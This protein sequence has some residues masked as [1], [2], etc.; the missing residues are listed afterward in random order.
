MENKRGQIWVETVIYTL[1]ALILIGL[2]LSF[3][4]P[5]ITEV[6]D[7]SVIQQ[8]ISTLNEINN[9]VTSIAAEGPGNKREVDVSLGE[10]MLMIDGV[11]NQL[12]FSLQST[13]Q[14]S[15][16]EK[17]VSYGNIVIFDHVENNLNLI[18]LTLNYSQYNITYGGQNTQGF[19]TAAS[20]PYK[21]F[22]T[23]KGGNVTNIDFSLG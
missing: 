8:S 5:K 23:N 9:V 7:K 6:Q 1:I 13:Y 2:V 19:I 16:P 15:E 10:G 20:T 3:V 11:N 12:V 14:F 21:V 22:I 18:N 4:K 17:N